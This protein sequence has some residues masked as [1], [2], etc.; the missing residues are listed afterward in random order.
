MVFTEHDAVDARNALKATEHLDKTPPSAVQQCP[1]SGCM[2]REKAVQHLKDNAQ[3]KSTGKCARHVRQA[4]EA[5]GV[6]LDAATRPVS[7]KDYGPYLEKHG[8]SEITNTKDYKPQKGDVMVIDGFD[9]VKDEN[10]KVKFKGSS[11]G[12][13]Q[14]WDGEEWVSD[15]RQGDN[16][17][18][19]PGYRAAK[20]T[21]HVYR[22]P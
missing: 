14:M 3:E 11:H 13:I 20:P 21:I 2:D 12:H 19:G 9:D 5:G 16:S 10:G 1:A 18:P 7:A 15:F 6:A 22:A 4:I 17:Y 8:F